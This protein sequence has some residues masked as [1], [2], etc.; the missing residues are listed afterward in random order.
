MA[1]F[2]QRRLFRE[3][4][5][6]L[7]GAAWSI[8]IDIFK[9]GND[10][11]ATVVDTDTVRLLGEVRAPPP[12]SRAFTSPTI[13][14][15]WHCTSPPFMTVLTTARGLGAHSAHPP[16]PHPALHPPPRLRSPPPSISKGA[17]SLRC[18]QC[19]L[20]GNSIF[21][22][23]NMLRALGRRANMNAIVVIID[24][25]HYQAADPQVCAVVP[26]SVRVSVHT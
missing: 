7:F 6:C 13:P 23:G 4:E 12:R 10:W 5:L 3:A 15:R 1:V 26:A 19:V 22:A 17:C 25:V 20:G 14:L 9:R 21:H 24:D 11:M 8:S 16:T 2:E 18:V